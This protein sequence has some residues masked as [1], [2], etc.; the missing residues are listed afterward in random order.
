M[1]RGQPQQADVPLRSVRYQ[2]MLHAKSQ[3]NFNLFDSAG[4]YCLN[5]VFAQAF[6]I[7]CVG[8]HLGS[9]KH[10]LYYIEELVK[11]ERA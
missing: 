8:S 10:L 11:L 9:L 3:K 6:P 2:Q 7:F 1:G 5:T 4:K